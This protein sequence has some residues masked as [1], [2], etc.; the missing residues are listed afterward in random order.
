[1]EE[2]YAKLLGNEE[3]KAAK[4]ADEESESVSE[5]SGEDDGDKDIGVLDDRHSFFPL[6]S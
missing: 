2:L 3:F 6:L 4:S 5:G 1:M